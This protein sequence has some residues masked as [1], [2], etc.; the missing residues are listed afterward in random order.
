MHH[1]PHPSP[2][3]LPPSAT[4]PPSTPLTTNLSTSLS[5]NA[6]AFVP[7]KKVSIKIKNAS[8]QEVTLDTLKQRPQLATVLPLPPSPASVKNDSK[9]QPIRI[10]SQEQKVKRL[11]GERAKEGES[12]DKSKSSEGLVRDNEA[13]P[14]REVEEQESRKGQERNL[15]LADV[16]GLDPADTSHTMSRGG[17]GRN[18]NPNSLYVPPN[19]RS[20]SIGLGFI[21]P[22]MGKSAGSGFQ[23]GQSS[24]SAGKMSSEKRFLAAGTGRSVYVTGGSL[25]GRPPTMERTIRQS[26][27]GRGRTRSKRGMADPSRTSVPGNAGPIMPVSMMGPMEHVVP[28]EISANRWVA[29]STRRNGSGVDTDSPEMVDR[30]VKGLLNKLTMERFDSISDQI[31][32][33]A[34]KSE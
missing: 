3:Q 30:K 15:L 31:I 10:E 8:G 20:A 16:I 22:S 12:D 14:R 33:W 2:P 9:R 18:R 29:G 23:M 7:A 28:L 17:S 5:A 27:T 13:S 25:G 11:A 24:T 4:L 1:P 21:P 34:N 26:G 32:A 19:A 6:G